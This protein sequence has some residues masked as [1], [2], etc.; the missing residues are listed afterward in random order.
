MARFLVV[1]GAGQTLVRV[2]SFSDKVLTLRTPLPVAEYHSV[3]G[4][5]GSATP[6]EIGGSPSAPNH[7]C[8]LVIDR[9]IE[10]DKQESTER[11]NR[12]AKVIQPSSD[13]LSEE[14][15]SQFSLPID[16]YEGIFALKNSDLGYLDLM[17]HYI[18]TGVSM[19]PFP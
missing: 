1:P 4:V 6:I 12:R 7:P 2:A 14:Q 11:E 16:Q 5:S 17:E 9:N 3:S 19:L 13:G 18:N 15:K 8:C 10:D